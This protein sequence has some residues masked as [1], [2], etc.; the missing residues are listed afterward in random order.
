MKQN[1]SIFVFICVA[2]V[3]FRLLI[4]FGDEPDFRPR[5]TRLSEFLDFIEIDQLL[6]NKAKVNAT[7]FSLV[8]SFEENWLYTIPR[9]LLMSAISI[10]LFSAFYFI[11]SSREFRETLLILHLFPGWIYLSGLASLESIF[12]WIW[13]G[14]I[15][16]NK[17]SI[18]FILLCLMFSIDLGNFVVVVTYLVL[19]FIAHKFPGKWLY[20]LLVILGMSTFRIFEIL[21][22]LI[23]YSPGLLSSKLSAIRYVAFEGSQLALRDKYSY[24]LRLAMT[25]QGLF[26]ITPGYV[27]VLFASISFMLLLF[28]RLGSFFKVALDID[29]LLW[30]FIIAIIVFILPTYANAKYYIF[31]LPLFL[32][33]FNKHYSTR[34]TKQVLTFTNFIAIIHFTLAII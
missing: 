9:K 34:L 33:V 10:I 3:A 15:A 27:K 19:S 24:V 18:K 23:D 22:Y 11:S 32:Q 5:I 31:G 29:V 28:M 16:A 2:I 4:P 12:L 25:Y 20:I 21:Q 14:F 13:I 17:T 1:I 6:V 30:F 7:P 8:H 26:I